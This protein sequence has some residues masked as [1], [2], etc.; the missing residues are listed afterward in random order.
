MVVQHAPKGAARHPC[1]GAART[2]VPQ[3][4]KE[5]T[6]HGVPWRHQGVL[7]H[8]LGAARTRGV[9]RAPCA[10]TSRCPRC[11]VHRGGTM[12]HHLGAGRT[13]GVLP[14]PARCCAHQ[15]S[16]GS[17]LRAPEQRRL[18]AAR[19]VRCCQH[20]LGAAAAPSFLWKRFPAIGGAGDVQKQQ[21]EIFFWRYCSRE[22]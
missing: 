18:G 8:R 22:Q 14:A 9:L 7:Q 3:A 6:V 16:A 21:L 5:P 20:H 1:N 10:H 19:T 4:P 17:V 15:S 13:R 11:S 2:T 12:Q